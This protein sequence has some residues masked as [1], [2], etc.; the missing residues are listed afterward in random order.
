MEASVLDPEASAC[1]V[2]WPLES[3]LGAEGW[4]VG[5]TLGC[6]R[7]SGVPARP[8]STPTALAAPRFTSTCVPRGHVFG[9]WVFS[10][11]RP[12][13]LRSHRRDKGRGGPVPAR[14][15]ARPPARWGLPVYRGQGEGDRR[16]SLLCFTCAGNM[17]EGRWGPGARTRT[18]L[19]RM[20]GE[21]AKPLRDGAGWR[22]EGDA[23]RADALQPRDSCREPHEESAWGLCP[24]GSSG[25]VRGFELYH[26]EL[27]E[28]F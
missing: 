16:F 12:G 7:T 27:Q 8:R 25:M 14:P 5:S 1:V 23:A 3:G 20:K 9:R 15:R 26:R 2:R 28:S 18:S 17:F 22:V 19:G 24:R 10:A 13:S 4:H 21:R 11:T 6:V